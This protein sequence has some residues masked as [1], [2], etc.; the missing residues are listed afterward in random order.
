MIG[1]GAAIGGM[2]IG[3]AGA[4]SPG[5]RTRP[6]AAQARLVDDALAVAASSRAQLSDI[7]HVVILMQESRSFDHPDGER[8]ELPDLRPVRLSV[9][10]RR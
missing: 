5:H 4:A 1:G 10:H 8:K 6:T 3:A 7:K 2:A 9:R